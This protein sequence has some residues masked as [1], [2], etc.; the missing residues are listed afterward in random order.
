MNVPTVHSAVIS[1]MLIAPMTAAPPKT[2]PGVMTSPAAVGARRRAE[3]TEQ[4][5]EGVEDAERAEHAVED[6]DRDHPD[7][8]QRDRQ[9]QRDLQ[10][11]PGVDVPQLQA[12]AARAA[13]LR[14]TPS[15]DP[16]A[17]APAVD[18]GGPCRGCRPRSR[19]AG[20]GDRCT[21]SPSP[22]ACRTAP[23]RRARRRTVT[24]CP[25]VARLAPEPV[26]GPCARCGAR[27]RGSAAWPTPASASPGRCRR[28]AR[29]RPRP[30]TRCAPNSASGRSCQSPV[31]QR[32]GPRPSLAVTIRRRARHCPSYGRSPRS[33]RPPASS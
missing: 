7:E 13:A 23:A 29:Q 8:E 18:S 11:R 1:T 33:T 16:R 32:R 10:R 2:T 30:G 22:A 28:P 21:G 14:R 26:A 19:R 12:G 25:A 5:V 4:V 31:P 3:L 9:D 6:A 20:G 17:G 27:R 15:A 24:A